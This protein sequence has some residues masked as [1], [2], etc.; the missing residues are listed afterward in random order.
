MVSMK[1]RSSVL[2]LALGFGVLIALIA[3]LGIRAIQ[4]A[5]IMYSELQT[6]QD[7]YLVTEALCRGIGTDMYS[8]G[9]LVRDYLLDTDP[10]NL[11]SHR[12][13][14]I[15]KRDAI[16]HQLD[17][18]YDRIDAKEKPRVDRLQMEAHAYW[19][20]L[21]PIFA[22]TAEEKAQ[23][24]WTFL[25]RRV[26]PHRD[27]VVNLSRELAVINNNTLQQERARL[28]S[29]QESLERFLIQLIVVSLV[30]G[31]AVAGISIY[32]VSSLER[33]DAKQRLAIEMSQDSLRRLS[34]RLVQLQ[35]SE[36]QS[37]SRELHDEVGQMMTA[38][39][40]QLGNIEN[41]SGADGPAFRERL[42]DLKRLNADTMRTVRDLAMGL[43]PSMLDDI[44]LEAALQWQ[45]REFSR[46]T[47]VPCKVHVQGVLDTLTETQKTCIYRVVQEALTNC[48]RHAKAKSVLVSV[49]M[50]AE[51]IAV[52]VSDDGIGFNASA[53]VKEGLGLLGMRER[54]EALD[55]NLKISSRPGKG[56]VIRVQ[57]PLGVP[58]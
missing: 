19:E 18:L 39:G 22:W 12:S 21:D 9:V 10:A 29:S 4:R 46:L 48:A 27:A 1:A 36:R 44:G 52:T 53:S 24:S 17:Q 14:L 43:R 23:R 58:A 38:L 7:A 32:R 5:S 56:T 20:S 34:Q 45:G 11:E 57:I 16:Q 8:A 40:I 25:N 55:G 33:I 26:L 3:A 37:L 35:E 42:E 54:V 51:G 31:V 6:S 49:R 28:R 30:L 47:G 41:L 50:E 2:V 15:A 13:E